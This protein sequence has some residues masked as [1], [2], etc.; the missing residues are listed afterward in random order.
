ML[1]NVSG[2]D[3]PGLTSSITDI[4]ARYEIN[5][6]DIGQ[7]VI[8]DTLSLGI[9]I[10]IPDQAENSPVLKEVLFRTH[11]LGI[12][13]RFTPITEESYAN[14]VAGQGK[15]RHIV[16]LLARKLHAQQLARVTAVM[17]RLNESMS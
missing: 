11:E 6:L 10:E 17:C 14:W 2:T 5:V 15:P 4:L 7:A 9:L 1:I 13:A 3:K 12:Q 16:T 8:H